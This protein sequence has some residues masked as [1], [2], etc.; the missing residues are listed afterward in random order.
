MGHSKRHRTAS[1]VS[2]FARLCQR[3]WAAWVFAAMGIVG[4][5]LL[6]GCE[7]LEQ[8][9]SVQR[10]FR[11]L[12]TAQVYRPSKVAAQATLNSIPEAEE[13]AD[14]DSPLASE[15]FKN[16][17]VLSNIKAT[18]F[19]RLMQAMS[20]WVAPEEGC[21]YC[22]NPKNLASD[23]K[24]T[25]VVARRMLQMTL[26]INTEWKTHVAGTGVTCWTCHRGQAVP[27]GDWFSSPEQT[28]VNSMGER[29]GQNRPSAVAAGSALPEDP[30][31]TFLIHGDNNI[32]VQGVVPMA[33]TGASANRRSVKQTEWT[34]SMMMYVSKSL[35]VNCSYCHATRAFASWEQSTPA[36]VTAWYGIR[37]VRN[38]NSDYLIPLKPLFPAHRLSA[39]GDGPKVGCLTCHKGAFK[40]L[41]GVSSL[42]DYPLLGVITPP[43]DAA[44]SAP[45][46]VSPLIPAVSPQ[47]AASA[48]AAKLAANAT[49]QGETQAMLA[50]ASK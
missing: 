30:L 38:L 22:H 28:H 43:P 2:G 40:P 33:A 37:M 23:E 15:V 41:Y 39:E 36:R 16:V 17:K 25:K 24:Y 8:P 44:A 14:P 34:Y 11:G 47:R 27:S 20:T 21:N 45:A 9:E 29:A 4:T 48:P 31:S 13:A 26:K 12:N 7:R 3:G 1:F 18:E 50:S 10:G 46:G 49:P 19:S 35:G 5:S 42:K 6:T 32:R